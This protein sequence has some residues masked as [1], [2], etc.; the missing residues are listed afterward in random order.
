M[1]NEGVK[2]GYGDVAPEAKENFVPVV[3]EKESFVD[4]TDL[5]K[6]NLKFNNYANP[7]EYGAVLLD[8]STVPFPAFPED[9][10]MG[11]WS[12]QIS[13][14]DGTFNNPITLTMTSSGQYSSQ[15]FTLTFDTYNNIFCNDLDIKWYRNSE[16]IESASF[17]PDSAFYFCRKKVENYDKVIFTFNGMNMP[18]NR[19]K[20]YVID[21]GYGTFFYG[22]ELRSVKV[23]QEINPISAEIAI[24]TV[25]FTI[26]SK[27]DMQYSFQSKQPLSV[28]YNGELRATAF[29]TKS[30]RN[31]KSQWEVNAEDYVGMLDKLTFLGGMYESRN[32]VELLKGM[33]EQAKIPYNISEELNTAAVTGYIPI[34]SCREALMQICFAIG[35]V[36]DTSGSETLNIYKL[37]NEISQVIPLDRIMQGQSFDDDER[38]TE[39]Q[40]TQHTYT[41]S[42]ETIDVY[43][44]EDSG[45]GNNILV[46]FS[47]PVHSLNSY[48]CTIISSSANHAVINAENG[49]VLSGKKYED[50]TVIKSV[51]NP[52]VSASDLENVISIDNATLISSNNIDDILQ[53]CYEYLVKTNK[54]SLRVVEGKECIRYGAVK[55]GD[56]KYKQYKF[57]NTIDV[58]DVVT[59]ETEY[60]GNVT[61]RIISERYSLNGGILVK[62]CEVV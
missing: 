51:K 53:K 10:N 13:S 40:L 5:Q 50:T 37:S 55:Y 19:L 18:Y 1:N 28:Y 36:A 24:N 42:T 59:A 30:K 32:A 43:K 33:L 6:Y 25:D 29:V 11:L 41:K 9:E 58:G 46:K 27:T 49:A 60:L 47:E 62:E 3:S 34:C 38:V 48:K 8:G 39:V 14:T 56:V 7:C 20:L 16:L 52:V 57:D 54:V 15:G 4:V 61:G 44:A 26:D 31:T 23:I 21:Y 17:T 2:I 35:A 22:D 12:T 45:T